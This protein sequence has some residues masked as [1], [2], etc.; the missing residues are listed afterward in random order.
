[1]LEPPHDCP[2]CA[3]EEERTQQESCCRIKAGIAWHGMNYHYHDF[4]M[5]KADKGPCR[6]GQICAI[7]S[8]KSRQRGL[9]TIGVKLMGRVST[10]NNR[11]ANVVKDE[12]S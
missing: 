3:L 6:L 5:I 11:P 9:P 7:V 10:L 12:V 2:V 1:M 8:P 4:V